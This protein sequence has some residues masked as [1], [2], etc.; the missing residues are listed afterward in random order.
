MSQPLHRNHYDRILSQR[1]LPVLA[2][3]TKTRSIT[4]AFLHTNLWALGCLMLAP[5]PAVYAAGPK[6]VSAEQCGQPVFSDHDERLEADGADVSI[7][8]VPLRGAERRGGHLWRRGRSRGRLEVERR[9]DTRQTHTA[10][11]VI[12]LCDTA[13]QRNIM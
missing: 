2:G 1:W 13:A 8:L 11:N 4:K 10:Q 6:D 7:C 3:R 5:Q 9:H 12:L